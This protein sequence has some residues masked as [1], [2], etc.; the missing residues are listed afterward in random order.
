M[1]IPPL[2]LLNSKEQCAFILKNLGRTPKLKEEPALVA[3]TRVTLADGGLV[4]Q[5]RPKVQLRV[6]AMRGLASQ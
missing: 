5:P 1:D 4:S 2:E 6:S 3:T